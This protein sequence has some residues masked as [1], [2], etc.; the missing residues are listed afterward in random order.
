M[1]FGE[2][3]NGAYQVFNELLKKRINIIFENSS[4]NNTFVFKYKKMNEN[5]DFK[6]FKRWCK[7]KGLKPGNA[8]SLQLYM[9]KKNIKEKE[10]A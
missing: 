4:I 2:Y 9:K 7:F 10:N 8:T 1:I 6:S 3:Y 5:K